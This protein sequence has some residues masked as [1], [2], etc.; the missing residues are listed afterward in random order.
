MK[1][2]KI[3]WILASVLCLAAPIRAQAPASSGHSGFHAAIGAAYG[4]IAFTCNVCGNTR[5]PSMAL[6]LRVG[7]AV[8]PDLVLSGE[9]TGWTNGF[10][11]GTESATWINLVAQYYPERT[12]G[13]FLKGGVGVGAISSNTVSN[14]AGYLKFETQ[15]VGGVIGM[16]FDVRLSKSFALTPYIDLLYAAP[17]HGDPKVNGGMSGTTLGANMVQLGLAASWR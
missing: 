11:L 2:K 13:F 7:G 15:S 6:M 1:T 9:V 16:G 3:A 8:R 12:G 5:E 17:A 14:G 4:S 10:S